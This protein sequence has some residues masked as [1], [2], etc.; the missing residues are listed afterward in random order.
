[1]VFFLQRLRIGSD[2]QDL[3]GTVVFGVPNALLGG[4]PNCL[5]F[6]LANHSR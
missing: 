2:N 3:V 6:E 1:M 4:K 5:G